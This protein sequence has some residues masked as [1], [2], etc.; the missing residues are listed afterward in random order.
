[1]AHRPVRPIV[2]R[3][4]IPAPPSEA[5]ALLADLAEHWA[6]ADRWIEVVA[7]DLDSSTI[8]LHAPFGLRRTARVRVRRREA[9][10]LVEGEARL[11]LDTRASVRWELEPALDD[12]TAV[13]LTATAERVT[14]SD[15]VLLALGG[16]RWLTWRFA[17]TLR[18]LERALSVPAGEPAPELT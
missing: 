4:V 10:T 17:V 9:P 15:R 12:A 5:F 14:A 8:R 11:G 3:R 13:T 1:V 18:R 7:I 16:R 6:L 2:A